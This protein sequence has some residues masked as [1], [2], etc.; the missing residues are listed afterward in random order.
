MVLS[1]WLFTEPDLAIVII[2]PNAAPIPE[3]M[4]AIIK[5]LSLITPV[6]LEQ[7]SFVPINLIVRPIFV[8]LNT[9]KHAT[10]KMMNVFKEK[11]ESLN[12]VLTS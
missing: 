5:Y 6:A 8:K 2:A 11:L 9:I 10:K 1:V 7:L 3:I 12:I 4:N